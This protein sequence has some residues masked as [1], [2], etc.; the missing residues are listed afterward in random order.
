MDLSQ[1]LIE[2]P[3]M[4]MNVKK[5]HISSETIFSFNFMK[6]IYFSDSKEKAS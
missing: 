2:Q 4:M 5:C 1:I 3:L 6:K